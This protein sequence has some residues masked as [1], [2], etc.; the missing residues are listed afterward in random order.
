MA[1]ET[2]PMSPTRAVADVFDEREKYP[3]INLCRFEKFQFRSVV[4]PFFFARSPILLILYPFLTHF[5]PIPHP[6][7]PRLGAV[8]KE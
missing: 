7:I 1:R 8:P 4:V 2:A 3:G 6:F 5:L